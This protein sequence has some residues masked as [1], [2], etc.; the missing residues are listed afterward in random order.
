MTEKLAETILKYL[1]THNTL[2]LS[3]VLDN[4]PHATPLFYVNLNFDLYFVS[5]P[6]TRHCSD[7]TSNPKVA[8][9][10]TEDYQN[11]Q[12]IKG[13]QLEGQAERVSSGLEKARVMAA[14]LKKYPFAGDFLKAPELL[15]QLSKFSIYKIKPTTIWFLDNAKGFSNRETLELTD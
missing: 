13:I 5:E 4:R 1:Q 7:L 12:E 9:A 11:W 2:I 6:K 14:Y 15:Q 8:A 3:T 10:I